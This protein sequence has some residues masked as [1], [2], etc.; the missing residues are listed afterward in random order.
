MSPQTKEAKGKKMMK[1]ASQNYQL[2]KTEISSSHDKV[3]TKK[4]RNAVDTFESMCDL[5]G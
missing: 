3:K 1:N 5:S 2:V 4:Q